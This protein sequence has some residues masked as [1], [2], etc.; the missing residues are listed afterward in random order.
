[1]S[2][3][4]ELSACSCAFRRD[5]LESLYCV[6]STRTSCSAMLTANFTSSKSVNSMLACLLNFLCLFLPLWKALVT[7]SIS[8]RHT[9]ARHKGLPVH[10]TA[11]IC[12]EELR[13]TSCYVLLAREA[14]PARPAK[15]GDQQRMGG[16]KGHAGAYVFQRCMTLTVQQE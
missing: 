5:S 14:V 1:M 13:A 9:V 15:G 12:T 3:S 6:R 4:H 10:H 8:R 16:R 11:S 7:G 2:I